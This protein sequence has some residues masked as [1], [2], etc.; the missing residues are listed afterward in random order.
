MKAIICPAY[1]APEVLRI[2]EIDKPQPKDNEVLVKIM[3]TA[4]NS[5]DVR[6]RGLA[7]G[8]FLR[9]VMRF[10]LGFTRPRKPVLGNVLSGVVEAVGKN[11]QAFQIGDAVFASTGFKFGAYA[12]YITLP[13]NSSIAHKPANASFEEAAAILFGGT[14]ALYFLQKAG[15]ASR[16]RQQVLVYGATGSVGTAALQIVKHYKAIVTA[17]CSEQG[18]ALAKALGSDEIIVYSQQDFTQSGK[19]FDIVFDAVGKTTKSACKKILE[20]GGKY[21]TVGGLDVAK[22]TREQLLQLKELFEKGAFKACIEQ[23]YPFTEMVAAHRHVDTGKKK[24]NVVV[25]VN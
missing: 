17:V 11:V 25:Q 12:D 23:T 1:G 8:G 16:P 4:V 24:G 5:G 2:T 14:T 10:V 9:I 7:V 6:V 19:T 22:E 18:V 13:E 3:A 21:V 20:K 15:I